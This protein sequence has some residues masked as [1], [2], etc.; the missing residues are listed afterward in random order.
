VATRCATITTDWGDV[1]WKSRNSPQSATAVTR[2]PWPPACSGTNVGAILCPIAVSWIFSHVGWEATF[3]MTGAT[4][5]VWVAAWWWSYE[6]PEKHKH[7]SLAELH[8]IK[9]GQPMVEEKT[10][11]V[12]WLSLPGYR[13][14]WAYVLAGILSGSAWGFYQFFLPDFLDKSFGSPTLSARDFVQL[15]ALVA[16]LKQSATPVSLYLNA[17]LSAE[18]RAARA[19]YQT[20]DSSPELQTGLMTDLNRI[21]DGPSWYNEERF[22]GVQLRSETKARLSKTLER[23]SCVSLTGCCW[24]MPAQRR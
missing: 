18:T 1:G 21:I 5:F 14:V 23:K 16:D 4:G 3:Y 22:K 6:T 15:P 24:K 10:I 20:G 7:L 2:A 8:Y 11:K 13:A 12:S 19:G 9:E 17:S